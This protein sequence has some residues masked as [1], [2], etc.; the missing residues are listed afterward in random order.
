MSPLGER[1][2]G[3]SGGQAQR[4]ALARV[5]LSQAPLVLLDEPTASLDE[6]TA[7]KVIAALRELIKGGRTLLIAT[8]EPALISLADRVVRLE[9]GRV[10][11]EEEHERGA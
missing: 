2:A 7:A 9:A 11:S 3:L 4:V 1:G 5:F 10:V 6:H 8:H